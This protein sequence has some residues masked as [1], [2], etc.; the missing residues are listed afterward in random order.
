MQLSGDPAL[1]TFTHTQLS[2]LRGN[3]V[4]SRSHKYFYF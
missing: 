3:K 2:R 1:E 4:T